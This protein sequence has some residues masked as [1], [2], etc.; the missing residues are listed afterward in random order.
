MCVC[1]CVCSIRVSVY[2]CLSYTSIRVSCSLCVGSALGVANLQRYGMGR[3][4]KKH[5]FMMIHVTQYTFMH[6]HARTHIHIH[7]HAHTRTHTHTHNHTHT[8]TGERQRAHR[9]PGPLDCVSGADLQ[10]D[11]RLTGVP[12][13]ITSGSYM[14]P[15]QNLTCYQITS[16]SYMLPN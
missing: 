3:S 8:H 11:L 12:L 9:A 5:T 16:G 13:H 1:A 4:A 14:L 6:I 7:T 15:Y 10:S 2:F